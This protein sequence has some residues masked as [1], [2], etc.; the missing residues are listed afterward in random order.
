MNLWLIILFVILVF[1]LLLGIE[2]LSNVD[3]PLMFSDH[4][5]FRSCVQAFT[6]I[7]YQDTDWSLICEVVLLFC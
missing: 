7:V 1:L 2:N 6:V 4:C 5:P 3:L